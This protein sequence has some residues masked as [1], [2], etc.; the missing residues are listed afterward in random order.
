MTPF[1]PSVNVLAETDVLHPSDL[2][3]LLNQL[4]IL[5]LLV[6]TCYQEFGVR[7]FPLDNLCR[8]QVLV[9]TFQFH[10]TTYEEKPNLIVIRQWLES[11]LLK[12]TARTRKHSIVIFHK[13]LLDEKIPVT[14]ILEEHLITFLDA[15]LIQYLANST[16]HTPLQ[17]CCACTC[18]VTH[19]TV[20]TV[21]HHRAIDVWLDGIAEDNV[22]IHLRNH[23]LIEA[24][25]FQVLHWIHT[26]TVNLC[27]Y[28]VT[29]QILEIFVLLTLWE[30]EIQFVTFFHHLIDHL[31]TERIKC[32]EMISQK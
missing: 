10:H 19:L 2:L 26:T 24:D 32:N 16:H 27:L 1:Y 8:L 6:P 7:I 18:D 5:R 28:N 31:L 20:L 15:Q 22:R 21:T 14:R 25:K 3:S 23:L 4:H 29:A 11:M 9:N 30:R 13:S 17:E 12:V